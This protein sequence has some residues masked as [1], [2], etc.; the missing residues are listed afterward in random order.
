VRNPEGPL[1]TTDDLWL[2]TFGNGGTA[3]INGENDGLFGT[4]TPID[5]LDGDEE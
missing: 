5:G 1:I 2:L 4:I 3:G